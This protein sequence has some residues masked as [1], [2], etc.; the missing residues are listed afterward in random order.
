[1]S[2]AAAAQGRLIGFTEATNSGA[3]FETFDNPNH[4]SVDF[5]P[6]SA[7]IWSVEVFVDCRY[8]AQPLNHVKVRLFSR[9][10]GQLPRL[11]TKTPRGSGVYPR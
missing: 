10:H 3:V 8:S 6:D 7:G 4:C 11:I 5:Q 9:S 2:S 1:M